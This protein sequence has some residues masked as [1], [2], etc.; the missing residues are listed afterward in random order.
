MEGWQ[1]ST[2]SESSYDL[3]ALAPS[4]FNN[5]FIFMNFVSIDVL[6]PQKK[7]LRINRMF[8]TLKM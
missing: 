7:P 8:T 1:D 6:I 3:D 5:C 4:N 2:Y